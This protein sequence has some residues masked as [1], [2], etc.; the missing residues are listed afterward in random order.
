MQHVIGE[1]KYSSV[2]SQLAQKQLSEYSCEN[3]Q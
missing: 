3:A 2:M 1:V